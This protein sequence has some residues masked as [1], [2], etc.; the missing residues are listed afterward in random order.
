MSCRPAGSRRKRM[1]CIE[2]NLQVYLN[3][4]ILSYKQQ[5]NLLLISSLGVDCFWA[6]QPP[7]NIA[8]NSCCPLFFVLFELMQTDI[9]KVFLLSNIWANYQVGNYIC[10]CGG[11]RVIPGEPPPPSAGCAGKGGHYGSTLHYSIIYLAQAQHFYL[12]RTF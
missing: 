5:G 8:F 7:D 1:S 11:I 9:W 6:F 2:L 12:R 10:S 3:T 4:Y